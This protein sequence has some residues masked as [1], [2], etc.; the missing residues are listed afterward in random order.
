ML[1]GISKFFNGSPRRIFAAILIFALSQLIAGLV[2]GLSIGLIAQPTNTADYFDQ[3]EVA[4]FLFFLFAQVLVIGL[5]FL[6]LSRA[7]LSLKSIG[8]PKPRLSD[9]RKG[10]LGFAFFYGLFIALSVILSFVLPSI[11]N[12][13]QDVG[14]SNVVGPGLILAFISLVILPPLGEEILVRG[15]LFSGLRAKMSFVKAGLITSILFSVAHLQ[16]GDGSA[17]VWGAAVDTFVLS[18]VLVYL[19][20]KTGALYAGMLVHFLNNFVAFAIYFH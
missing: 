12:T 5:V 19:R 17:P 13:P 2:V 8:L 16:L 6:V 1:K 18:L 9:I 3:S 10:L 7:K 15:Y 4:Q 14:F 20:E 11:N